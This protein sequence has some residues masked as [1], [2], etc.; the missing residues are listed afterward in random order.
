MEDGVITDIVN[1]IHVQSTV[2]EA[3]AGEHVWVWSDSQMRSI[4]NLD[5]MWQKYIFFCGYNNV[6]ELLALTVLDGFSHLF[7]LWPCVLFFFCLPTPLLWWICVCV[8][9]LG[10]DSFD[11][12]LEE[13]FS[14]PTPSFSSYKWVWPWWATRSSFPQCSS[15]WPFGL[16]PIS[17]K[18]N[19]YL[20]FD[21]SF[22][23]KWVNV[24]YWK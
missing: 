24:T 20:L 13:P 6:C 4:L 12:S 16:W 19:R 1:F 18:T 10:L 17:T 15:S 21:T 3:A 23:C 11:D 22:I 5:D 2:A 14:L 8:L 7:Y 9:L